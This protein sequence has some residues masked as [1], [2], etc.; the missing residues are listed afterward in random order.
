MA[1]KP[2]QNDALTSVDIIAINEEMVTDVAAQTVISFDYY[3]CEEAIKRLNDY[4]NHELQPEERTDVLKHL[5]I[6]KPCL[7]RFHFEEGLLASLRNRVARLAAPGKL[8]AKL[9]NIFRPNG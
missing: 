6:C 2:L 8:R 1:D 3:S 7:E 9:G 5:Q 4:L